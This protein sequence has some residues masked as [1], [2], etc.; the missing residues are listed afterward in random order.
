VGNSQRS[1]GRIIL[2]VLTAENS[3]VEAKEMKT[4][5]KTSGPYLQTRRRSE[6]FCGGCAALF[7]VIIKA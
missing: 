3:F 6:E 7:R 4:I 2:E 5:H 1:S